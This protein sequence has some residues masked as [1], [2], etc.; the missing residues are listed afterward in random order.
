MAKFKQVPQHYL[1][2]KLMEYWRNMVRN[3]NGDV[4][5]S[6]FF[7]IVGN[8]CPH[9][10]ALKLIKGVYSRNE[11]MEMEKSRSRLCRLNLSDGL[12]SIFQSLWNHKG[13]RAKCKAVLEGVYD[14]IVKGDGRRARRPESIEERFAEIKR[15][16]K[17]SD[18]EK[19]ILILSY[20]K[21]RTCFEWPVRID[22][23]E[24]PLYYAMALDRSYAEVSTTMTANGRL[25]KFGLLDSDWDF[26]WRVL[27]GYMDGSDS[28]A[29]ERR[30]YRKCEEGEVL[31]WNFF[32]DLAAKDGAVIKEMVKASSPD[33]CKGAWACR[34]R[35]PAGRRGRQEH[36]VGGPHG[37]HSGLQ[38]AG[39]RRGEPYDYR[40]GGRAPSRPFWR[41]Q[42]L[43][44]PGWRGQVH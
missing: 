9:E 15:L 38:R 27:D 2:G 4:R 11:L 42:H 21:S 36:E 10:R 40:R 31:P 14:C 39:G 7:D 22:N 29:L 16:L 28:E 8:R 17:L 3:Y 6:D 32:G 13:T 30:F 26:N 33:A 18:L 37:R 25:R 23:P 5:D 43:R 12:E 44:F 19:E 24:K 35:G 34:L 41:I 20:V 1:L